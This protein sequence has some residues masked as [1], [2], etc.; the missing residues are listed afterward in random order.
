M[1]GLLETGLDQVKRLENNTGC[2]ARDGT[3]RHVRGGLCALGRHCF[4]GGVDG[5]GG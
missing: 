3:T 1:P 4:V 5:G 2:H